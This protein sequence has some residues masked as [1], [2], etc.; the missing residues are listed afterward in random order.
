LYFPLA[1]DELAS[2]GVE[3]ED[4]RQLV[5][6]QHQQQHQ[7]QKL[8]EQQQELKKGNKYFPNYLILLIYLNLLIYLT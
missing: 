2:Y 3:V 1:T 8:Q 6:E 4:L 7:Q 5:S